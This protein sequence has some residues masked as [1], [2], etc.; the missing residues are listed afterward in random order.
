MGSQE[1][2]SIK[3][4]DISILPNP[5]GNPTGYGICIESELLG[6][7]LYQTCIGTACQ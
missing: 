3:R 4:N 1:L 7:C 2:G 5:T 6:T